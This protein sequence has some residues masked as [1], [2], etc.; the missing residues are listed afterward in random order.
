[1][2]YAHKS[3]ILFLTRAYLMLITCEHY[4]YPD[5]TLIS[6]TNFF[7]ENDQL[8]PKHR[9]N[10]HYPILQEEY[11]QWFYVDPNITIESIHH[12]LNEAFQFPRHVSINYVLKA[13]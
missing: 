11:I 10:V 7:E 1:M 13:I 5:D 3:H 4:N 12:H 2:H 6:I 8:R 9:G